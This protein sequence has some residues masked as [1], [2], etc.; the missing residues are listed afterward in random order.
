[1]YVMTAGRPG[2]DHADTGLPLVLGGLRQQ[3]WGQGAAIA[4][5]LFLLIFVLTSLQRIVLRDKDEAA[6]PQGERRQQ[7][8]ARRRGCDGM[9]QTPAGDSIAPAA[10]TAPPRT[11]LCRGRRRAV[12]DGNLVNRSGRARRSV[13]GILVIFALV[14]IYP[15][16]I[17]VVDVVQDQRRR[18]RQPAAPHPQPVHTAAFERLAQTDFPLWFPNCVIVTLLVTVGRV[19]LRLAGRATRWPA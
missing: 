16:I 10:R 1:M 18:R 3:Q 11:S 7:R 4:F 8:A 19:L 2:E 5:L 15:F 17:Q 14:Y 13:Y 12:D 9:T 6:A